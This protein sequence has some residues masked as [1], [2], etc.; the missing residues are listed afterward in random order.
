MNKQVI[1]Q[2]NIDNFIQ[3]LWKR[4]LN[5]MKN[6]LMDIYNHIRKLKGNKHYLF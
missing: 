1:N 4:G 6:H 2:Q 5:N 3:N